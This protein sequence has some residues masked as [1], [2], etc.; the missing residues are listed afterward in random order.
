MLHV[1]W[2]TQGETKT[3]PGQ[4][5]LIDERHLSVI[6]VEYGFASDREEKSDEAEV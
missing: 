6:R 3:G 4:A 2:M 1:S 5:I